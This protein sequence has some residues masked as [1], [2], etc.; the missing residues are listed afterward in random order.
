MSLTAKGRDDVQAISFRLL[1][2]NAP[3]YSLDSMPVRK[4]HQRENGSSR[5]HTED[6][7][8]HDQEV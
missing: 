4:A 6:L 1:T 5:S 7:F 2:G 8:V 3:S